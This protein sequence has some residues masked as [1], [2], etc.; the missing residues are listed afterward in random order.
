[1]Q[2]AIHTG[3]HFTEEERLMKCLLRNNSAFSKRG[4]AIPGPSK[5]RRLLKQTLDALKNTQAAEGA[6]DILLDAIIDEDDVNRLIISNA[7]FF[8]APRAAVRS[9]IMYP[10]APERM[11]Q[12]RNLFPDD[13]I[14][15]FMALRNPASLLPAMYEQSPKTSISGYL[16]VRDP[17]DIRWSDTLYS[18]RN[19]VPDVAITVWC[20]EDTP[21]I[22][23][24]IL[25][26]IAGLESDHGVVGEFD[27]LKE[28]MSSEGFGRFEA[29]LKSHPGM[30]E[31][32]K[33]RVISAFLDKFALEEE[34]EDELDLADWTEELM[35]DMTDVY[36]EDM[37]EVQRIPDITFIA[38]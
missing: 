26:E 30:T 27:L 35:D 19:A 31:T 38:P 1:M 23:A 13:E 10:S 11:I 15:M 24:Q 25:R 22:W 33:R 8:G 16:G 28:I 21:L 12:I 17:C 37:L 6:R 32:Q 29:Y 18:I 7:H 36:D 20:S 5:Y 2:L 9:G 3:A 4:I 34:I 14:E